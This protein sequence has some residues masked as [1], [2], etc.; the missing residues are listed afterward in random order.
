MLEIKENRAS[1]AKGP[2]GQPKGLTP[3]GDRPVRGSP[4][5]RPKRGST[6]PIYDSVYENGDNEYVEVQYRPKNAST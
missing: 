3:K 4:S 6:T 1:R 2:M 5:A